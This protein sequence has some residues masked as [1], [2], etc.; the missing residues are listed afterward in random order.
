MAEFKKGL[1]VKVEIE[2]IVES[3]SSYHGC[4]DIRDNRGYAH[5][6]C[7][8]SDA[9]TVTPTDPPDWPPQVGDIWEAEG[10]EYYVRPSISERGEV[11]I[12][13]FEGHKDY[14]QPRFDLFK[15]LNPVL[16]RRRGQ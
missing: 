3:T 16:V 5:F 6:I 7:V 10:T 1:R 9:V 15:A 12:I 2:G 8:T 14:I 13:G 4:A 11:V